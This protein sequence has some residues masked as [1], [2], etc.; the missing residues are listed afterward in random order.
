VREQGGE[1]RTKTHGC[2]RPSLWDGFVAGRC[3]RVEKETVRNRLLQWATILGQPVRAHRGPGTRNDPI[4]VRPR[5]FTQLYQNVACINPSEKLT[6]RSGHC[7]SCGPAGFV[8][9]EVQAMARDVSSAR[10]ACW[11][12]RPRV[13]V[14]IGQRIRVTAIQMEHGCIV[15]DQE[16]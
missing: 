7:T 15:C 3:A 14:E 6:C 10:N 4:G 9:D 13:M 5:V 1:Y 8:A 12:T 2:A 16:S 11:S